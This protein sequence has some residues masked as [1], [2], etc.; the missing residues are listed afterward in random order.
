[1]LWPKAFPLDLDFGLCARAKLFNITPMQTGA[2][3]QNKTVQSLDV[4]YPLAKSCPHNMFGPGQKCLQFCL[5]LTEQLC[6]F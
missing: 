5:W 4:K 1:M 3:Q 6:S 2:A